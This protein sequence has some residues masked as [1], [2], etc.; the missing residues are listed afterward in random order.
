MTAGSVALGK[1][2]LRLIEQARGFI[3]DRAAG[4][5][6]VALDPQCYL[7]SWA[8]CVGQARLRQLADGLRS[9][10]AL[11]LQRARDAAWRLRLG[12][13]G[14]AGEDL[15]SDEFEDMIVSWAVPTDFAAGGE[16]RDR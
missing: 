7:N 12:S 10:T 6:D 1:A 16:Y 3:D 11:L 14:V 8:A 2:Q 13:F 9:A 4:G 5:I 15:A